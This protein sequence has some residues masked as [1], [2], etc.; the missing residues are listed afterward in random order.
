MKPRDRSYLRVL[1]PGP[2]AAEAPAARAPE[3]ETAHRSIA[4]PPADLGAEQK[5]IWAEII[6]HAGDQLL[7]LDR[8]VLR[9][10]VNAIVLHR[11]ASEKV[12]LIGSVIKSPNGY[13]IQNPYMSDMNKQAALILR[14]SSELG[15]TPAARVRGKIRKRT[16]PAA[17]PFAG[18]KS[19]TDAD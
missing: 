10:L 4:E 6:S 2:G 7:D 15:L 19:F 9:A 11:I 16:R 3:P 17:N 13:P 8:W 18:L 12:G 14:Y 5:E 1:S